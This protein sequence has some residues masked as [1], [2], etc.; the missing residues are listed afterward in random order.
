MRSIPAHAFQRALSCRTEPSSSSKKGSCTTLRPYVRLPR[1][2]RLL[3]L[4]NIFVA[5]RS[6]RGHRVVNSRRIGSSA[7]GKCLLL[8]A[9]PRQPPEDRVIPLHT[10]WLL[11][12]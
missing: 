5:Q 4:V 3:Q 8:G 12:D 9:C 1:I 7:L 10:P 11:V 6:A 2:V